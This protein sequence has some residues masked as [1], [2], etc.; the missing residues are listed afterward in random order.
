M[1]YAVVAGLM[2]R[3]YSADTSH[4]RFWDKLFSHLQEYFSK[5][6]LD[7]TLCLG[8]KATTINPPFTQ[9]PSSESGQDPT[10][11]KLRIVLTGDVGASTPGLAS[12]CPVNVVNDVN[13]LTI[14]ESYKL[15]M[16][17]QIP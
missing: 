10:E 13:L 7:V 9:A 11:P 15:A 8:A 1:L 2:H 16:E 5:E 14:L 12:V 6:S 3:F 4:M 17:R